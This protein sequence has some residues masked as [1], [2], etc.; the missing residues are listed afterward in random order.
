MD[1]G[2]SSGELCH[3]ARSH[4][5]FSPQAPAQGTGH[6]QGPSQPETQKLCSMMKITDTSNASTD[7][8]P[9]PAPAPAPTPTNIKTHN[10]FAALVNMGKVYGDLTGLFP[11]LSS[12]QHQYILTLY[13]YDSNTIFTE[14]MKNRTDKEM[15]RAYN[16]LHHQMLN[17][18]LKPKLKIMYNACSRAFRQYMGEQNISLQLVPPHLHHQNASERAI[19]TFKNHF[20]AG[21]CSVDKQFPMHLWWELLHQDTL[22]SNLMRMLRI[23]PLISAA[24]HIFGQFDFNFTPLAPPGT[25]VVAHVKPTA[26]R[27]WAPHGEEAWY[28]GPS[29]DH[30][31]CY[32]V[33]MTC[34]NKK[35]IVD[36]L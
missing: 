36:T 2:H 27:T 32:I 14:P 16:A 34:T 21:L 19:Q 28:V 26:S 25:R 4:R 9:G 24:T 20:M 30:Y 33:W 12:K 23:N 29:K 11:V 18:G 17:A 35:R 1:K 5:R 6:S 15:I 22:T 7:D 10:V 31:R 3:M 8:S 13:D